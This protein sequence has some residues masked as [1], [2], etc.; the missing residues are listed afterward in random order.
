MMCKLK[1]NLETIYLS[2]HLQQLQN[3][4]VPIDHTNSARVSLLQQVLLCMWKRIEA[5]QRR[6]PHHLSAAIEPGA[7]RVNGMGVSMHTR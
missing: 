4:R 1:T 5:L 7:D 6:Y 2:N 3:N